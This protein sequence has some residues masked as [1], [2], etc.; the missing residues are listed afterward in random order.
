MGC[1]AMLFAPILLVGVFVLANAS[2]DSNTTGNAVWS[3]LLLI[4]AVGT[5]AAGC[6]VW[7]RNR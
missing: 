3:W 4:L 5:F 6:I 2:R 1:A 7:V